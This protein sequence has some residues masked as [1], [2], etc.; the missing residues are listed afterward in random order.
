MATGSAVCLTE[1]E[2]DI[3]SGAVSNSADL[4]L[5]G[6]RKSQ[7]PSNPEPL[8]D[9][10]T[11]LIDRDGKEPPSDAT[12]CCAVENGAAAPTCQRSHVKVSARIES[13][14]ALFA[15]ASVDREHGRWYDGLLMLAY[16][17]D[18]LTLPAQI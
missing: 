17:G 1:I 16:H 11:A 4:T 13:A 15:S 12:V 14:G 7:L 6:E 2:K 9:R 5:V 8:L 3:R 10:S 18:M